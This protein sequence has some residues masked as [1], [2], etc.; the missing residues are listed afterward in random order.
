[1][2]RNFLSRASLALLLAVAIAPAGAA[3]AGAI[4]TEVEHGDDVV[5]SVSVADLN[6]ATD[7]G[8][9]TAEHRLVVAARQVCSPAPAITE[10]QRYAAYKTC[11]RSKVDKAVADLGAPR[12]TALNRHEPSPSNLAEAQ[13]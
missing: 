2:S 13:R 8:A 9:R 1:M 6:L 12:V 7:A 5:V 3:H 10:L 4:T 11:V